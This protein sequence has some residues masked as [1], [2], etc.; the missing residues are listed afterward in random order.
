MVRV[1][2][3]ADEEVLAVR[4]RLRDLRIDLLLA[5]GDLPWDYLERVAAEVDAPAAF[6]PGNHDP[7]ISRT[8]TGPRGFVAVDER[9]VTVGGLR[10]AGLG[11]CVRYN[12][13]AHQ[14][15]QAQYERKARTMLAHDRADAPVDVLLTHAPP[16]GLG[17]DD[18][19]SHVGIAALHGVLESLR[20]TWH[21]H[22]HIHPFGMVKNDRQVGPTTVRN[23]IPW[24]V[25]EVEPRAA[26]AAVRRGA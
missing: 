24:H 16:L 26:A 25:V 13:G 22:G 5:A 21:L 23:V 17:D 1:L 11:G 6:V 19:P 4:S 8:S 14:Y 10:V 20:P 12:G 9:I 18:D 15:T 2:A 3:V 7:G